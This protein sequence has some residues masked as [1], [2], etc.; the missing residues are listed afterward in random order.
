MIFVLQ[1][2]KYPSMLFTLPNKDGVIIYITLPNKESDRL[3]LDKE[4][5]QYVSWVS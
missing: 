4:F 3:L 2:L 5:S 1:Q